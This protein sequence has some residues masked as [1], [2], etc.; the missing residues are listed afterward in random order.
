M[1]NFIFKKKYFFT[2][3]L[4]L[5]AVFLLLFGLFKIENQENKK[6]TFKESTIENNWIKYTNKEFNFEISFPNTWKVHEDFSNKDIPKINIYLDKYKINLPLDNFSSDTNISIFPKG[7]PTDAVIGQIVDGKI[8]L[9]EKTSQVKNYKLL[10]GDIWAKY[11]TFLEVPK[12]W[13]SWGFV[14]VNNEIKNLKYKCFSGKQEI[15]LEDCNIY[16]GDIL[17]RDGIIDLKIGDEQMRILKTFNF[18]N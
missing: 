13:Q 15:K 3:F 9:L 10:N 14:W 8:D 11:V 7:I 2:I 5:I 16:E 12:N 1:I 6:G 4:L 18:I 17:E